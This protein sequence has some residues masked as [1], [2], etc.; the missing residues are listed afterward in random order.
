MRSLTSSSSKMTL[1]IEKRSMRFR[2]SFSPS[3]ILVYELRKS[4]PMFLSAAPKRQWDPCLVAWDGDTLAME[5]EERVE[6]LIHQMPCRLNIG[7]HVYLLH[8]TAISYSALN[9]KLGEYQDHSRSVYLHSRIVI[10]RRQL[11]EDDQC[12]QSWRE[13]IKVIQLGQVESGQS[14]G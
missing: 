2:G 10:E 3:T 13:G 14:D 7:L 9:R 5:S 1:S 8:H 12:R 11:R 6:E 4:A